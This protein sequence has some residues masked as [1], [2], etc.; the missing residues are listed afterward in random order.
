MMI[1]REWAIAERE[2]GKIALR[3]YRQLDDYQERKLIGDYIIHAGNGYTENNQIICHF[4]T[5]E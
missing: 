3:D 5:V 1:T 4:S 2:K